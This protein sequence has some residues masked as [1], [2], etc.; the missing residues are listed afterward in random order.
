MSNGPEEPQSDLFTQDMF[1]LYPETLLYRQSPV[2]PPH[3]RD[4]NTLIDQL[5]LSWKPLDRAD[6]PKALASW[7]VNLVRS[8]VGC[9]GAA[10]LENIIRELWQSHFHDYFA[11][12][13]I[14]RRGVM[15]NQKKSCP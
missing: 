6:E 10:N 12:L 13:A 1:L 15:E 7:F 4:P 14:Y 3:R 9:A 8:E 11:E 5:T 2:S